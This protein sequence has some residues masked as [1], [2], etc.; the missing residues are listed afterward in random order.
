MASRIQNYGLISNMRGAAMV[1]RHG[2]IDWL[3]LPRFDSD[4]CMAALLG[5]DEHGCWTIN[6]AADVQPPTRH[7]RAG[8]MI[9]ETE[10]ECTGGRVRLVDFM[11]LGHHSIIRIVEGLEGSVPVDISLGA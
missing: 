6:P 9:L 1:S 4:A 3:C 5:R 10:F 11:P 2:S 8:T 7:Y